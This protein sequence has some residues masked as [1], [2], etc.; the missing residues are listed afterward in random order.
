[1]SVRSDLMAA[2]KPL[3][4]ANI[5]T[6]DVPRNLDGLETNKPVLMAYRDSVTKA[7]NKQGAWLH[8]FSAWI[9]TPNIDSAKAEDN[10]DTALENVIH[11]LDQIDWLDWSNAE[12]STFGDQQAPAY[13][14]SLTLTTVKE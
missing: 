8:S 3:L 1:M 5:R 6:V 13:R 12:R 4:P 9:I 7:A 2:I 11:A 14:I 10:L